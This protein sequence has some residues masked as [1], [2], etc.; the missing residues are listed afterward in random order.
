METKQ[1]ITMTRDTFV[2]GV[3]VKRK[4]TINVASSV[5]S[6]L[7]A[8]GKAVPAGQQKKDSSGQKESAA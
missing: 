5:A 8:R 2:D 3:L 6:E 1:K 7:L 4:E